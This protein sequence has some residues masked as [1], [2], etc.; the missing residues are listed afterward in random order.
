MYAILSYYESYP[1]IYFIPA[2]EYIYSSITIFSVITSYSIHYTKLYEKK[3]TA[4]RNLSGGERRRVAIGRAFFYP[5][6]VI[7]M[8]EAFVITSY[9]IHYTK[10]YELSMMVMNKSTIS[11][12]NWLPRLF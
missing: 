11:G 8:D 5:S 7:L 2:S 9:S 12:Q 4:V 3:H 10:L 1:W 6:K